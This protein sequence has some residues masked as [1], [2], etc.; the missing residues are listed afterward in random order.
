MRRIGLS[1]VVLVAGVQRQTE[2]LALFYNGGVGVAFVGLAFRG[3][4]L[5]GV[6]VGEQ[7]KIR[8]VLFT[9]C[10]LLRQVV[11]PSKELQNRADQLLLGNGLVGISEPAEGLV[12]GKNAVSER[13]E[14]LRPVGG[15]P[16]LVRAL[17]A[18]GEKIMSE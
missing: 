10:P 13:G 4:A 17:Y 2:T 18:V 1:F 14:R 7:Q 5:L 6:G 11:G 8:N 9:G 16:P 15:V 3:G 12:T